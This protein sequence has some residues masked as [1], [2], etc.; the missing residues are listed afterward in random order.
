M[1]RPE[2]VLTYLLPLF[3]VALLDL[4]HLHDPFN[5][6][7]AV[8]LLGAKTLD[9]GGVLYVD[10]WC[11]KQPGTYWF[12]LAAGKLFGFSESGV[13]AFELLFFLAFALVMVR[14]LRPYFEISYLAGLVPVSTIGVY[15][16]TAGVGTLTQPEIIA[17]F[18]IY[19]SLWLSSS[20]SASSRKNRLAMFF[21]G[22]LAGV[23][24]VF[25]LMFAPIFVSFWLVSSFVLVRSR[26]LKAKIA[27]RDRLIPALLGTA[28]V[29]GIIALW[30]WR[31]NALEELLW[32][33]FVWPLKVL[34]EIKPAPLS[35]LS[36]SVLSFLEIYGVWMALS[37]AALLKWR[38]AG[39]EMIS[40]LLLTW[41]V[42]GS[43]VII[44]QKYSWWDYQ[45]LLLS[46]PV[47]ILAVRG[48]DS[49]L[50]GYSE[51]SRLALVSKPLI[52]ALVF[53][54]AFSPELW[55]FRRHAGMWISAHPFSDGNHRQAFQFLKS[56]EYER[57]WKETRFLV[58]GEALPGPIYVFGN[59]IYL[60]QSGR[61][62]AIPTQGWA[63]EGY[64]S[65]QW[66]EL[67]PRLALASPPYIFSQN[68]ES[69]IELKSPQTKKWIDDNYEAIKK[70]K[71]GTW[72]RLKGRAS[73]VH[74]R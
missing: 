4:S 14:T 73:E 25:K 64:V 32:V 6:D 35:R 26:G 40:Y 31:N 1:P 52:A 23:S 60:L 66:H 43:I 72:Y 33:S 28:L 3:I 59:P 36:A 12:F 45:F 51:K 44:L 15:Y 38:R 8:Y 50:S 49:L 68:F 30:F 37:S 2:H 5:G 55:L 7:T 53:V 41:I 11:N 67:Q 71:T 70:S 20:F 65:D 42:M 10:Y 54:F 17:T 39:R 34:A 27:V 47:G 46:V 24:V 13:H 56:P 58:S 48:L 19:L 21:S 63:W 18:S 69:L 9:R 74:L 62:Y 57:I 22:V 29:L 61:D 16:A